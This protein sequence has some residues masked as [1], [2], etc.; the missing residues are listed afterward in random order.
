MRRATVLNLFIKGVAV[1]FPFI[2]ELCMVAVAGI[3][4]YRAPVRYRWI[5]LLVASLLFYAILNLEC[6]LFL[7][8]LAAVTFFVPVVDSTRRR[9][10]VEKTAAVFW[11]RTDAVGAL[12]F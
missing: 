1:I 10:A 9:Q 2:A 3:C 12:F 5:C 7:L 6:L 11:R 4:Y 8:P